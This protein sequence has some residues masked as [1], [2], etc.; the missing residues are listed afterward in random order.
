MALDIKSIKRY[1][2]YM[3]CIRKWE[4]YDESEK[5]QLRQWYKNYYSK[6]QE[7]ERE[8]IESTI[9]IMLTV[10]RLESSNTAGTRKQFNF[11]IEFLNIS[12][13]I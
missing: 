13:I 11:I 2:D 5:E 12:I 4:Y 9:I 3:A 10:K 7:K 1:R 8:D 6:N